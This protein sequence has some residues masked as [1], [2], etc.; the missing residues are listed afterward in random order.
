MS[1]AGD[2]AAERGFTLLELLVVLAVLGLAL[3]FAVPAF[4]PDA[5]VLSRTG[6]ELASALKATRAT[7]I[8]QG[9]PQS[10]TV[11]ASARLVTPGG[12]A[13]VEV[14]QGA[15]L[16]FA[17]TAGRPQAEGGRLVFYPDGS[18]SGGSVTLTLRQRV[19]RAD[20]DWLTGRIAVASD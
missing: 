11:D 19:W 13:S 2:R 15:V 9:R 1:S 17:A 14:P 16:A 8:A 12:A 5:L 3:T 6:G 4:R 20:I 7:A 18:A 10:V